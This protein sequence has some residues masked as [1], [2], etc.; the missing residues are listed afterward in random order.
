MSKK[1]IST[2]LGNVI[3]FEIVR[4]LKKPLFWIAA[5]IL[6]VLLVGYVAFA[7]F[8][9][10]N[11][12][13]VAEG[14]TDTTD[15][16]LGLYD[17]ADYL[18]TN[19]VPQPDETTQELTI[20]TDEEQGIAA[21]KEGE[22]D[23]FY[24]LPADFGQTLSAEIYTK[25]ESFN[26]FANYEAPLR[27]LLILSAATRI[28][29]T[30]LAV[31]TNVIQ[32]NTTNFNVD[33]TELDVV[34]QL[35]QMLIPGLG[36]VLFYILIVTFGNR[37]TTAMVEEKENRISEMILT[38]L[39]PRD[40]ITGK[41]ISLI[42]LG[43]I[44][45]AI[46]VIPI[47]AIT[48]FGFNNNIIPADLVI[49]FNVWTILS[50]VVL[51]IFSFFLFTALCVTIGTLVPTAKDAG[52][53]AGVIIILVILPLF[54]I[55]SFMSANSANT[56]TYFLSYFPPS[57]PIA[58]MFRNIFGTLSLQEYL[59]GLLVIAISSYIVI[60][61]S[62]YVYSRTAIDFTSRVNI[63]KLLS[64]PRKNWKQNL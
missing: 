62:V 33:N 61:F 38:S 18:T 15:L 8:L 55:D 21:V 57:A 22:I 32:I 58:L 35:S 59:I 42:I 40:L 2:N 44:Q 7:A 60:R 51:L 64:S 52:Q 13:L 30:D 9:G 14:G 28:E 12:E 5:L 63:R 24:Y 6:P 53:F 25:S 56:M 4:N 48:I 31:V 47:I 1:F 54:F 17:A 41:I 39:K 36:L 19:I 3:R 11:T 46:L 34:A 50:T 43:F 23:V 29:P 16:Q 20:F 49:D 10:Y 37:L 27:S 45:L 26:I